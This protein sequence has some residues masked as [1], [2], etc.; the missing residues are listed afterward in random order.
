MYQNEH[1]KMGEWLYQCAIRKYIL[2]VL[3]K[4]LNK[5][6]DKKKKLMA[7]FPSTVDIYVHHQNHAYMQYYTLFVAW[8]KIKTFLFFK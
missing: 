6:S 2:Q 8:G 3:C 1:I 7:A 5:T 4:T